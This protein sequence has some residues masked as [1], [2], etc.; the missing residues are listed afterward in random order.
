MS[1]PIKYSDLIQPDSSLDTLLQILRSLNSELTNTANEIKNIANIKITNLSGVT[2]ASRGGQNQI[3]GVAKDAELL[4]R[5]LDTVS[6]LSSQTGQRIAELNLQASKLRKTLRV[7]AQ[8]K[9]LGV[10]PHLIDAEIASYRELEV[11]VR[12][13][14]EEYLLMDAV[15]RESTGGEDLAKR[16]KYMQDKM[17]EIQRNTGKYTLSVGS[18]DKA[19]R[20][21]TVATSQIVRELPSLAVGFETFFLAISNNLPIFSDAI[22][23]LK[24]FEK[25]SGRQISTIKAITAA[26]K[27]WTFWLTILST[28]LSLFGGQILNSIGLFRNKNKVLKA[29]LELYKALF[30]QIQNLAGITKANNEEGIKALQSELEQRKAAGI[31]AADQYKLE[32]QI[33]EARARSLRQQKQVYLGQKESADIFAT[34]EQ[35]VL[36]LNVAQRKLIELQRRANESRKASR[37]G[38]IKKRDQQA[39]E[40]QQAIVD[41]LQAEVNVVRE[42][43]DGERQLANERATAANTYKRA[44]W[45]QLTTLQQIQN[46]NLN[47]R[48]EVSDANEF[49]K[50]WASAY[51]AIAAQIQQIQNILNPENPDFATLTSEQIAAYEAQLKLL[52]KQATREYRELYQEQISVEAEA[53]RNTESMRLESLAEGREKE[54][55]IVKNN[56]ANERAILEAQLAFEE[57]LTEAQK[58]EI[59]N[60]INYL[61]DLEGLS[62][63]EV[64]LKYAQRD[65]ALSLESQRLEI[66]SKYGE[67]PKRAKEWIDSQIQYWKDYL[68]NLKKYG[69]LSA[70]ELEYETNRINNIIAGLTLERREQKI[71]SIWEAMGISSEKSGEIQSVID[72]TIGSLQELVSAY[73]EVAAAAVQAADERVSSAQKVLDA[74][75][76]ARNAGYAS[77]V[78]EAQRELQL[79]RANQ[80]KALQQQQ[81]AQRAQEALSTISQAINLSEAIAK[82][83]GQF[84][85]YGIPLV[86]VMLGSFIAAKVKAAQVAKQTTY[87]DGMVEYL[88]YG[89]SHQSGNDIDFGVS[90]D[91][92]RRRVERG[93]IIGVINKRSVNKFGVS[94]VSSIIESLN[95]GTFNDKFGTN[96]AYV[97][98]NKRSTD[99]SALE[100]GVTSLV[101]QGEKRIYIA[102]GRIIEISGSRKRIIKS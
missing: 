87:G 50:S 80:Q 66:E 90:K 99:L 79:A 48:V 47:L 25:Q 13:L 22:Q 19:L 98:G 100:K 17:D 56:F 84:G 53:R 6:R 97:E 92:T 12:A 63:K 95:R 71:G 60:Q 4:Q 55:E 20:G 76:E 10:D 62:E 45:E 28:V 33:F 14:K 85:W 68:E 34:Y 39:I 8:V 27:G 31:S 73:E 41:N 26:F 16:L 7:Q 72:S 82:T 69:N 21:V 58:A 52:A 2:G 81:E 5:A 44:L 94:T 51:N 37:S 59:Q 70:T 43:V 3:R 96:I 18:Y 24:E 23:R 86:S 75:I 32:K 38:E 83:L 11:A 30:E 9:S 42:L 15:Q 29:Q 40:A 67:G 89:G 54:L 65:L 36:K 101:K 49:E 64:K 74:E 77:Q 91:G 102:E 88:D 61:Y 35:S 93:E 46:T 57:G 78:Q 1:N